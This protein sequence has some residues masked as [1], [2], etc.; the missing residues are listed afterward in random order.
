MQL[1]TKLTDDELFSL[2]KQRDM[3]AFTE[4]YNRYWKLLFN[5]AYHASHNREESLDICQTLFIW[6]W[7]N[8]QVIVLKTTLKGYLYTAVKY[9]V[10]NMI[11]NGKI[12]ES[13]IEDLEAIDPRRYKENELEVK[14]LKSFI[15]Q[16][17]D[18]LPE[19]CREVFL[20]SRDEQLSHKE[21]ADQLGIAEKTVDEQVYRALKK[22][23]LPLGRLASIFLLF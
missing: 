17:I 14:E 9:K 16:L 7:E 18:E 2:L 6:L 21:I 10:A 5:A 1:L 11:R 3:G 15:S 22:L 19:R 13:L 23:R 20:L 8:S 12:R 4:I